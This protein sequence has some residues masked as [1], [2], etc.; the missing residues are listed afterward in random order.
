MGPSTRVPTRSLRTLAFLVPAALGGGYVAAQEPEAGDTSRPVVLVPEAVWDG[1]ADAPGA[2]LGRAWSA[3]TRI[4]AVGPA[5]RVR[6]PAGRRTGRA[7]GS[8][9]HSGTHRGPLAPLPAPVRRGALGRP[10][11]EGAARGPHGARGRPRGRHA[12][13]RRHH[14]ARPRHRGR[15]TTTCSCGG[16]SSRASCPAR[17]SSRPPARSSPPAATPR[18]APTTP[19]TRRRAPR[20]RAG[21][22]RSCGSCATRSAGAPTGSR[23]TP[24]TAGGRTAKAKPTFS[25]E[26]LERAGGDGAGCRRAGGRARDDRGGD[27]AGGARR[28][29]DDRARRRAG[30]PRCSG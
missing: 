14:R 15:P 4:D 7:R 24:T 22:R 27:A 12:P 10:G 5:A 13:R 8:D 1:V 23:S 11:A 2:R 9:A 28:R 19:S 29:R 25:Q 26:E 16:R 20:R 6:S 30:R 17:G 3:A 21:R 18:G